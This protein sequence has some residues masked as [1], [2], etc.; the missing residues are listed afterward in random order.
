ML[1]SLHV[2]P[3]GFFANGA[4]TQAPFLLFRVHLDDLEVVLLACFQLDRSAI[5]IRGL[6]IVAKAF[7]ALGDLNEGSELREAQNLAVDHVANAVRL[8]ESLPGV[9]L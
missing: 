8:E 4:Q 3:A 1:V 2:S 7:D 5:G 9:R 6:R